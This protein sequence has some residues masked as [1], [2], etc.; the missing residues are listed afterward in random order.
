MWERTGELLKHTQKAKGVFMSFL[1]FYLLKLSQ[2][3][4]GKYKM[5]TASAEAGCGTEAFLP[6]AL[7]IHSWFYFKPVTKC[8]L[9]DHK[10]R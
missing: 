1:L 8:Q 4:K 2:D 5:N 7:F 6:W 10:T 3:Q 9:L